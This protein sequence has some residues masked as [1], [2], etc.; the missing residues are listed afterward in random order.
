MAWG[1]LDVH[2]M[3]CVSRH[4]F[5]AVDSDGEESQI[6]QS[7]GRGE[8]ASHDERGGSDAFDILPCS[9]RLDCLQG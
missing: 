7:G 4:P 2:C 3:G 6:H 9:D 5:L 1:E 8:A